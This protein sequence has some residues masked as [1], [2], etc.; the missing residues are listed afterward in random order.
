MS[1]KLKPC[2]FCGGTASIIQDGTGEPSQS[3]AITCDNCYVTS[4]FCKAEK[5]AKKWWNR[6]ANN[7]KNQ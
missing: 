3:I 7:G 6:R 1:E 5:E 2:P 4:A